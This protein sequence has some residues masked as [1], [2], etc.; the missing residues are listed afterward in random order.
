MREF[1][2]GWKRKIGVV[3]LG[4]ACCVS[5]AWARSFHIVDSWSLANPAFGKAI[6]V[7]ISIGGTIRR[8]RFYEVP[9]VP[10]PIHHCSYTRTSFREYSI[11]EQN[12]LDEFATPPNAL[13]LRDFDIPYW[14]IAIPLTIFSAWCLLT[15]PRT[16]PE[17]KSA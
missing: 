7:W 2:R 14:S 6:H 11:D 4:L 15:K 12:E 10:L 1:F 16:K 3:V 5:I 9:G 8:S 17:L 13:K